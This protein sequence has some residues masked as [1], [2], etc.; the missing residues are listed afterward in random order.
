MRSKEPNAYT[1]KD[2]ELAERVGAQV[3]WAI[4]NAQLHAS[5]QLEF[6]ERETL[7]TIG[8][9]I[10]ST[11]DIDEIYKR[12]DEELRKLFSFD[13]ISIMT[14]DL[15][16]DTLTRAYIAG[17]D[18]PGWSAGGV[19]SLSES[20]N[21]PAI[22]AKKGHLLEWDSEGLAPWERR[23]KA[24]ARE[25]GLR[26][27][28]MVPLISNDQVIGTF[29][30]RSKELELAERVGAQVAGAIANA[31]LHANL[32]RESD[33]RVALAEIGRVVGSTLG[34]EEIYPRVETELAKLIDFDHFSVNLVDDERDMTTVLY[35]ADREVTDRQRGATFGAAGSVVGAAAKTGRTVVV[36][37]AVADE[38]ELRIR[39]PN[40][41]P[42]DGLRSFMCVPLISL[43]QTIGAL[44]MRSERVCAY[45]EREVDLVERVGALIAGAIVNARLAAGLDARSAA[46]DRL[47][48]A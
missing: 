15:G 4:S 23:A 22:R 46:L 19:F 40:M 9:I 5:L 33:E 25:A 16:A 35:C 44:I 12:F 20:D 42:K 37:D 21:E 45:G 28:M 7:A 10:S 27:G 18:V 39:F 29:N 32:R 31:Q 1:Q 30:L 47:G 43:G 24:L 36:E 34:I 14:A 13:R 41:V 2:I 11:L 3:A 8:R 6:T 38:E 17:T 26:S 48:E